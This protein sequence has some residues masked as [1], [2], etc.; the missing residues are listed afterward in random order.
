MKNKRIAAAAV[1][2]VAAVGAGLFIAHHAS[3]T[4]STDLGQAAN[5]IGVVNADIAKTGLATEPVP[6]LSGQKFVPP[7]SMGTGSYTEP[8]AKKDSTKENSGQ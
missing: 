3:T 7:P 8:A 1:G 5:T 6:Q 4:S 2:F